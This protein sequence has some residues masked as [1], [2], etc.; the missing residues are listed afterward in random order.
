MAVYA[1]RAETRTLHPA[2]TYMLRDAGG[3]LW[4]TLVFALALVSPG[5]CAGWWADLRGFRTRGL[6][7][8]VAWSVALSFGLGTL[9]LVAIVWLGGMVAGEVVL[10]VLGVVAGVIFW[11]HRPPVDVSRREFRLGLIAVAG[12]TA[13]V[14][15]SLVDWGIGSRLWMSVTSYDHGLRT[16]F[17]DAVMR[18]GVPTVNPLYW[19][20]QDVSLRYY[21]FWYVTCGVV[22]R[23]AHISARQALIAS[24]VWP[25]FGIGAM[26]ALFERYMLG[27]GGEELRRK[28]SISIVLLAVTGLDIFVAVFNGFSSSFQG[29]M[30]WWSIDHVASW[31]DTFLW[32]PHHAA[33]LICCLL[34]ML[35][36]WM[37]SEEERRKVRVKMAVIAGISLAGAFGLSTY[38][39]VATGLVLAGWVCWEMFPE[40]KVRMLECV[41]V[42]ALVAGVTLLPYLL[43]LLHSSGAGGTS[44]HVLGFGVRQMLDPD[45]LSG[46]TAIELLK[47][48]HPF[49]ATQVVAGVLLVPGYVIEFGFFAVVL[50]V[51]QRRRG[52][53]E[54]GE[55][56]LLVW[57]WVGLVAAT[58]V[59]SRV[60]ATN[61]YGLRAILLPQFLLLP[62][63]V[64]VF[65]RSAGW[66]R[67]VLIGLAV[68][69][70]CGSVYQVA[71]LRAF[72]P[73]QEKHGNP[74]M[75]DLAERNYALRAA[76]AA[77]RGR[78]P[79]SARVQYDISEGGYFGAARMLENNH[80]AIS[81]EEPCNVS[82]G[83]D[84]ARC[85]GIQRGIDR[86]FPGKWEMAPSAAEAGALCD[87]LGADA[88]VATRWDGVWGDSDGWVWKLPAVVEQPE[89]R[90]VACKGLREDNEPY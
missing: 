2:W 89:V 63:A 9:P 65:E 46:V 48:H 53:I 81:S 24:C 85:R 19:P 22:G 38:V 18:T 78:M 12:W 40:R 68:I 37:G 88:L 21:Y 70:V 69:G 17:V 57:V 52:L 26:L 77:L 45:L 49:A 79:E 36:L 72:L 1:R 60:I 33:A 27:W 84:V 75:A 16:A 32:V 42:A 90:V 39:A 23:L 25:V 67:R 50:V 82:F 56:T 74:L 58:F 5:Y 35:L 47:L 80:Q 76:Y 13:L 41:C 51:M 8:Q 3:S 31:V 4:G 29:D 20:G 73:W 61:D 83:G 34:A 66:L 71:M 28:W 55:R 44:A 11:R 30:E 43:Q 59:R 15:L 14:L 10:V 54:D 87:A 62:L 86:L 6:M 7:E 64:G